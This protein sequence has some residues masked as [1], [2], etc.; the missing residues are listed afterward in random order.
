MIK[1]GTV[2]NLEPLRTDK[3][4]KYRCKVVEIIENI[5][6]IDYPVNIDTDKTVFLL[7]G[8]QLKASFVHNDQSV[9]LFETEVLGRKM[10]NIPM[11]QLGY[12]GDEHLLKIQRRQ[13]VRV[14]TAL[15]VVIKKGDH[16]YPTLTEDISAGGSA[17]LLKEDMKVE[18]GDD[19]SIVLVFP[20]QTGEYHYLDL[21]VHIVRIW[22]KD[23]KKLASVEFK[24]L[25]SNQ[26]QI[27][28]R[29]CFEKQL[30]LRK[31]GL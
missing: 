30:D 6:Y 21:D 1:I 5:I 14:D 2:L 20:M 9:F 13:F 17:I 10:K 12:P 18:K 8:T 27:I 4:E 19:V 3:V 29:Y 11:I 15:D 7:D 28:M 24:E 23:K 31:K 22:E 25:T 16:R 26:Q